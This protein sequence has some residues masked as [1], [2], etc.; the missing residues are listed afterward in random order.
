[1]SK[2]SAI[3]V[4]D[5]VI[6][7]GC[8]LT[9]FEIVC[10]R[11]ILSEINTHKMLVKNSAS[12]RAIPFKKV[13]DGVLQNPFQPMAF[14]KEHPGMV[15]AEYFNIDSD[16][17]I[18]H[19]GIWMQARNEACYE[20][21]KL[22]EKK[23]SKQITN[24]M[25]EAYMWH[26]VLITGTEWENFFFLRCT[27]YT[28]PFGNQYRSKSD[29]VKSVQEPDMIPTNIN[30]WLN[31]NKNSAEIHMMELAECIWDE[32]NKSEPT[33]LQ[34]GEWHTPYADPITLPE[35]EVAALTPTKGESIMDFRIKISAGRNARTSF[36]TA[37]ENGNKFT[38]ESDLGVYDKNYNN[39]H[40]SPF[41]HI[42]QTMTANEWKNSIVQ[43]VVSEDEYKQNHKHN[44]EDDFY[45]RCLMQDGTTLFIKTSLGWSANFRGFKMYR[46]MLKNENVTVPLIP[47]V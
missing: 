32:Y 21:T 22:D 13:L 1:M 18:K 42:G 6:K 10:P 19:L 37:D 31:I 16:E 7:Q 44:T 28:D 24:R 41:E 14:P 47:V 30:G 20:A 34:P 15:A 45:T 43:T 29:Y 26:K 33:V 40:F 12:S 9:T 17:H 46:K 35:N 27:R 36:R 5:S 3:A 11:I 2:I 23:V 8:R 4:L 25:L 38:L 39:G